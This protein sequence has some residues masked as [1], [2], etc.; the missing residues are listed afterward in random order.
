[1]SLKAQVM[2]T[3][4]IE[5]FPAIPIPLCTTHVSPSGCS[6]IVILY[7]YPYRMGV[8]NSNVGS[9]PGTV[10]IS[11]VLSSSPPSPTSKEIVISPS[12]S[13]GIMIVS[14]SPPTD[15]KT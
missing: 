10:I 4:S 8:K 6:R 15:T 1:M 9:P 13:V 14:L 2:D 12:V 5:S 7:G 3:S 11:G